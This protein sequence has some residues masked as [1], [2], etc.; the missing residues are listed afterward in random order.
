V[1][2]HRDAGLRDSRTVMPWA[3][4]LLELWSEH[5]AEKTHQQKI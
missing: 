4:K 1:K 3:V 5:E 2:K